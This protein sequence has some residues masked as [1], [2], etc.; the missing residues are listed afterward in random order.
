MFLQKK[1]RTASLH[2]PSSETTKHT[3]KQNGSSIKAKVYETELT[4][5]SILGH[6]KQLCITKNLVHLTERPKIMTET[7]NK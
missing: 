3:A 6:Q 4:F 7:L 5:S 1:N 2:V